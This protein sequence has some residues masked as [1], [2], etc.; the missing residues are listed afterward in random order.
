MTFLLTIVGLFVFLFSLF[1][2]G[3][4]SAFWR[5][6]GFAVTGL[7]LDVL[8]GTITALFVYNIL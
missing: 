3:F 1:T 2:V 4:K 7:I 8:I 5:L 6:M